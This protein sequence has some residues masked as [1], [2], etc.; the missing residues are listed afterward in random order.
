MMHGMVAEGEAGR[1]TLPGVDDLGLAWARALAG[2]GLAT[3]G[4]TG[5][6]AV[7]TGL[8]A[9]LLADL[10]ADCPDP[11]L[12]AA[13]GSRLLYAHLPD[14]DVLE[15]TVAVL[16]ERLGPAC[17]PCR[18]AA[19]LG[20][21]AAGYAA[22]LRDRTRAEQ[23]QITAAAFRARAAAEARF[24][25]VFAGA[26]IGIAVGE[27]DGPIVE[28]NHALCAMLGYE[29]SDLVGRTFW[30][31]D[32][33]DDPPG[34]WDLVRS[35]ASGETGHL[36][37]DKPLHRKD[38]ETILCDIVLSLVTSPDGQARFIVGMLE[39]ITARRRL[40]D[41]LLHQAR[42]DPLTGLPNRALFFERLD[43][44]IGAGA[45][46]GVCYLD[47]DGF[48]AVNDTLGHD[49]GDELLRTVAGRLDA[50]VAPHLVA[51]MGGDEFVVLVEDAAVV[52]LD[53]VARAA[54]AAVRRPVQLAGRS[55][56]VSASAGVVA[57]R[58]GDAHELMQ[59][60]DATLYWAKADGRDRCA[61][62]DRQRH[63]ADL[64]RL[65]LA[66]RMPAA[67]RGGEFVVEYQPMVRLSDRR[68]IGAEALLRWD[69]PGADRID[70]ATFVPLAE[71]SG[72]ILP[73]GR[74]VLR[75]ACRQAAAWHA[76]PGDERLLLSV[77]VTA[78]QIADPGYVD[79]VAAVLAE[80]GWP[81]RH[82]QL[83]L[84]ESAVM[85]GTTD[86]VEALRALRAM[87]VRIAIDDFGTGYS[88]FAYLRDLPIDTLKLAGPLVDRIG[89]DADAPGGSV[90]SRVVGLIVELARVLGV[91][92]VAEAV[93]SAGQADRLAA[94]GCAAAQGWY[95]APAVPADAVADLITHGVLPRDC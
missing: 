38:G 49:A 60:A 27:V 70:P 14:P 86:S 94:L 84:T 28:A 23:Q 17:R 31:F 80:T 5:L 74:H 85:G 45:E 25:A 19:L 89:E 2:T 82:L 22:A 24:E 61:V 55:L 71:Q 66:T 88:N 10:A 63:H 83:E 46:V 21:I 54:L 7:V 39:D 11:A 35:V 9:D 79:D 16:A 33:P 76:G 26:A 30:E 6:R 51:R 67:L 81:A 68:M 62:F 44:A 36:R 15:R 18:L 73:L 3:L 4:G 57:D 37:L 69:P 8:A 92:V 95:F 78:H 93:E 53:G 1:R 20:G 41:R 52:R 56:T 34:T 64:R 58:G 48:K 29:A 47:L 87:E 65:A 32:H 75:A 59:A 43:A 40:Q 42:H 77:N 90:T 91:S 72:L 12:P 13:L 50:A